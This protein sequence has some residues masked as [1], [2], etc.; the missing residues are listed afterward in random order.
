MSEETK[1]EDQFTEHKEKAGAFLKEY[2][3]IVEKH[4]MDFA[5]YPVYVP[6]G[7]GGF[8]TVIQSTPIDTTK[9]AQKSP[10]VA[11]EE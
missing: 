9:I 4:K 5:M 3:E 10:F 2:G 11:K 6:D 8:R 7:Q 1:T